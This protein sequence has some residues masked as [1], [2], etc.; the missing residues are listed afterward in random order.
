MRRCALPIS[1]TSTSTNSRVTL[2]RL[3]ADKTHAHA[4]DHRRQRIV[5]Q[6][7]DDA[8]AA[9]KQKLDDADDL[10]DAT[11][12]VFCGRPRSAAADVSALPDRLV[13]R[14]EVCRRRRTAGGADPRHPGDDGARQLGDKF[15]SK[16]LDKNAPR[17]NVIATLLSFF[18][19]KV[20]HELRSVV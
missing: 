5:G 11:K 8:A 2:C 15:W 13:R 1:I 9:M 16:V 18:K 6:R 17:Y 14:V 12:R 3:I 19:F 4:V 10:S 20:G 7:Q